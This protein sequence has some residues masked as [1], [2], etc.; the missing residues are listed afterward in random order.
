MAQP[1]AGFGTFFD[2]QRRRHR[3][4][5]HRWARLRVT[6]SS[7]CVDL[8]A[9]RRGQEVMLNEAL[10]VVDGWSSRRSARS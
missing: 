10:N 2:P 5:L 7:R 6:V 4:C 1:P 8:D 9:P 3:R